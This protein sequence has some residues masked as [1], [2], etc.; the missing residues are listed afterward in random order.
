MPQKLFVTYKVLLSG[1]LQ[2]KFADL[3]PHGVRRGGVDSLSGQRS[4]N[5]P[6]NRPAHFQMGR[7]TLMKKDALG[8]GWALRTIFSYTI[9]QRD[10]NKE[11]DCNVEMHQYFRF[12]QILCGFQAPKF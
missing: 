5:V 11:T 2:K 10:R 7:V 8:T 4:G 6:E 3:W 12:G 9:N 1:L